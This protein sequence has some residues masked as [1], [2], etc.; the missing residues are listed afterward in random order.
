[1]ESLKVAY[2][3]RII[4]MN[5]SFNV[6]F[7]FAI[8]CFAAAIPLRAASLT[9]APDGAATQ[10]FNWDDSTY[11][12]WTDGATQVYFS[13]NDDVTFQD[14]SVTPVTVNL[15]APATA[16]YV[17][18]YHS[19]ACDY[20]FTGG[21]LTATTL[22]KMYDGATVFTNAA[23]NFTTVIVQ[24]GALTLPTAPAGVLSIDGTSSFTYSG[25]ADY[26]AT[27]GVVLS[28][29]GWDSRLTIGT[30]G[31]KLT[32]H[33]DN[34]STLLN[35]YWLRTTGDVV[36]ANDTA[37]G[38]YTLGTQV[39]P[40]SGTL[41]I[42]S[43]ETTTYTISDNLGAGWTDVAGAGTVKILGSTTTVN[44]GGQTL[45]GRDDSTH[46]GT[47]VLGTKGGADGP[48][49]S[50]GWRFDVGHTGTGL[51][52]INANSNFTVGTGD[53]SHIGLEGGSGTLNLNDDSTTTVTG[54][55]MVGQTGAAK[56]ELNVN[57]NAS[58]S[59]TR[60][61][62]V[63]RYGCGTGALKVHGNGASVTVGDSLTIGNAGRGWNDTLSTGT[64]LVDGTGAEITVT[65]T[66]TRGYGLAENVYPNT[67]VIGGGGAVGTWTQAAGS[68]TSVNPVVLGEWNFFP[69]LGD[70]GAGS[71]TLNLDGGI[72]A[73]PGFTTHSV[74]AGGTVSGVTVG[75][76]NFN[77]GTVKATAA[78]ADF[79][80]DDDAAGAAATMTLNV[81]AGG[82]I[83]DVNGFD[84][85][86]TQ[87]LTGDS[88][89]GGLTVL[90]SS[91]G[92]PGSLTLTVAPTYTGNT[93]V[94]A[95]TLT[96]PSLNTPAATVSVYDGATL[97][98]GSIVAD[99]LTI[100]GTPGAAAPVAV[101]EPGTFV[102]LALAAAGILAVLRRR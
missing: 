7:L 8:A 82:A 51:M 3:A 69:W 55:L 26:D 101:P 86:I 38:A 20:L 89:T 70:Q 59:V 43:T 87:P 48:T 17:T 31:A 27:S 2:H 64:A 91:T 74:L 5:R 61:L 14:L 49:V 39:Q 73:A 1:M 57:D 96:V 84:I 22:F 77:G 85:A 44:I 24:G 10:P 6:F 47:L 80:T 66:G 76:V 36:V 42:Q 54:Y 41:T 79:F 19:S 11:A 37:S 56:G 33:A 93:D 83:V 15:I 75:I 67:L 45:I 81:K 102:L 28:G 52:D 46:N 88:A 40:R 60:D 63:G 58:L 4:F 32:L 62:E 98:A 97:N 99:A 95:G 9:F 71:G 94:L 65:G 90:D 12:N 100:G 35:S 68:T 72:V 25:S 30:T 13:A 53:E 18:F 34:T 78:N 21:A 50:G 23:T 92:T 16:T 29:G